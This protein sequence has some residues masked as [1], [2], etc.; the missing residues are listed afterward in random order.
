MRPMSW[1]IQDWQADFVVYGQD[2]QLAAVIEATQKSG[3]DAAWVTGWYHNYTERQRSPAPPFILLITPDKLYVWKRQ[4][5]ESSPDPTAVADA[6][7][8]FSPYLRRSNLDPAEIFRQTFKFVVGAWLAD[9]LG[10]LWQPETPD[11]ISALIGTGLLET[12]EN[13]RVVADV[14]A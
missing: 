11:E 8:L 1:R 13:G 7:R 9:F 14:A 10:H 12:V 3:A 6:S 4:G 5:G 2:G